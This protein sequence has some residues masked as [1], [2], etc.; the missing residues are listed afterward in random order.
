MCAPVTWPN[1]HEGSRPRLA[2]AR[3]RERHHGRG[4]QQGTTI[5]G[6]RGG[7]RGRRSP[8]RGARLPGAGADSQPVGRRHHAGAPFHK[9]MVADSIP[10]KSRTRHHPPHLP[11]VGVFLAAQDADDLG[12][13]RTHGHAT[14]A[15]PPPPLRS[16]AVANARHAATT[17]H[18]RRLSSPPH[19]G[20]PA[21]PPQTPRART[22]TPSAPPSAAWSGWPTRRRRAGGQRP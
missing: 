12:P 19:S 9:R 2:V 15:S 10:N 22:L 5:K 16:P 1:A 8:A 17:S 18:R 13:S 6:W 14:T 7:R 11:V 21:A 3:Q 20:G 4:W